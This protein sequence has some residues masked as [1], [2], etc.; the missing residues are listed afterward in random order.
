MDT[1]IIIG[2]LILSLTILV[3]LHECGHFFPAKWFNTKVE[4]FYLFFDPW[5]SL[6]KV[7]KGE[8][9]YGIGW[10]P[11][12]GYVKI[13]GMIDES[14]DKEHLDTEPQP[15]E[16]RSKPSWQRLIIMMGGVTV[17]FILGMLIFA[18]VVFTWGESFV[19]NSEIKYGI[20]VDSLGY[21]IGL[22][23]GDKIVSVG[24][25]EFTKFSSSAFKMEMIINDV[26]SFRVIRDG[27][28]IELPLDKKFISVLTSQK[29]KNFRLFEPR[30]PYVI[31]QVSE[32]SPAEK[33]GL[34][35]EDQVIGINNLKTIYSDEI[36]AEVEKNAG[37]TV[38]LTVLRTQDTLNLQSTVTDEGKLG[39]YA[40]TED[41][42]FKRESQKYGF[43]ESFPKGYNMAVDFL[44]G[45][46]KAFRKMFKKEID[47]K[48]SLG[49]VISIAKQ[50]GPTWEW[51]RFWIMTASLSILLAFLNLLPIPGLDGGHVMFLLYEM[52]SG[53]KPS[54]KVMEYATLAGFIL[55]VLLMIFA[56][57]LDIS[58]LF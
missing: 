35:S 46:L 33:A 41:K 36:I 7:K 49:S 30:M 4:K 55:L 54:D 50:F 10:L 42:Y 51:S 18:M 21:E 47:Y 22:R 19:P 40:Y 12:G 5:F 9:E 52:I 31:F 15:W 25:L 29:N 48:E 43:I 44:T 23:N 56:L 39:L 24:D 8:T 32:G 1:L 53:R 11:L 37:K 38:N 26:S 27:N 20:T 58:R 3:T 14:F 17:N 16:F 34:Q 2:Q 28:E 6:F 13:A 45:Q 57:G